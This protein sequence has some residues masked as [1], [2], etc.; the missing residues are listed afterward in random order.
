MNRII[1]ILIMSVF[2]VCAGVASAQQSQPGTS[3][4]SA[5]SDTSGASSS[6]GTG[7][8]GTP[9]TG[10]SGASGTSGA[11]TSGAS[12]TSGAGT[13]GPVAGKTLLGVTVVEMEAIIIG[14][15]AKKDL[16]DKTVQNDKKEKIGKIEDI[17][18]TPD[19]KIP[20]ASYAIIG[21][22]GFLG[23]GR[24]DVA[25]PMEQIKL[26]DG[27]LVLPGATKE[28]LKKLPKFEYARKK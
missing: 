9:G 18:V 11:G 25:I 15:S 2:Y 22:G 21:V 7:A 16:L 14:W 13:T 5:P 26:Q 24:N 28:A 4:K 20:F 3:D 8:S 19:A 17:I 23:I 10:A 6:S 12:G 27:N 1:V